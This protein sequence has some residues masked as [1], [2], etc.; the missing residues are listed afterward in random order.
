M[1]KLLTK[2]T[3]TGISHLVKNIIE[4]DLIDF[5]KGVHTYYIFVLYESKSLPDDLVS[6]GTVMKNEQDHVKHTL[7][8]N[9]T[10]ICICLYKNRWIVSKILNQLLDILITS[11]ISQSI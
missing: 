10:N 1:L 2:A 8:N 7:P 4:K 6:T 11:T 3:N 9:R 5:Y